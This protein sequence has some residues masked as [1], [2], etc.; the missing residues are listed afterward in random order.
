MRHVRPEL[1]GSARFRSRI[2][3]AVRV[4]ARC[5][6]PNLVSVFELAGDAASLTEAGYFVGTEYLPGENVESILHRCSDGVPADIAAYVVKQAAAALQCL[7]DL[8]EAPPQSVGVPGAVS[9]GVPGAVSD[10]DLSR[11]DVFYDEVDPSNVFVSYHG[12]VK[13]LALGVREIAEGTAATDT[14]ISTSPAVPRPT[15]SEQGA[16]GVDAGTDARQHADVSSLGRLLWTCLVGEKPFASAATF[17]APLSPS[18]IARLPAG[19]P[20]ALRSIVKQALALD[21]VERFDSPGAMADEL[22]RYLFRRPSRPTPRHLRRWLEQLFGAER[23]LLQMRV[24]RG[25]DVQAALSH[26]GAALPAAGAAKSVRAFSSPRPRELWSTRYST[27]SQF[28]RAS[29]AHSRPLDRAAAS[30]HDVLSSVSLVPMQH[31]SSGIEPPPSTLPAAELPV[32]YPPRPRSFRVAWAAAT[33]AACAALAVAA[34][35]LVPPRHGSSP[36]GA[37]TRGSAAPDQ[38]GGV[39][40]RSTPDGAAVFIDGEPTGL[41]TPAVLRGLAAGRTLRVR[42]DKAGYQSREQSIEVVAGSI[43]ERTFEL[44]AATGQLRFSAAPGDARV[45]VDDV[46][47]VLRGGV[48]AGL[49]VGSHVVRVE[50]PSALLF[51]GTVDVVPGEQ[52]IQ[53]GREPG[54]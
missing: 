18:A 11:G 35:M 5:A 51:S 42:V 46:A 36:F 45:Y 47:V 37:P 24:V 2:Q 15:K 25:R 8:R 33:L 13:W 4:A 32:R 6:H 12:T 30:T 3:Q 34:L 17:D 52:T 19:V 1:A 44:Y 50:T 40:V 53:L 16:A 22:E 26:L 48:A 28:G 10:G 54:P 7:R 20:D 43:E 41:L 27:F 14:D 29:L 38:S 49:S 21:P 23:A 9:N 39:N 31:S